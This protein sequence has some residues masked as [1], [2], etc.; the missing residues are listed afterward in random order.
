MIN[1]QKTTM[2]Y[3]LNVSTWIS[4][5]SHTLNT[6]LS[7]DHVS[8]EDLLLV[9]YVLLA[10]VVIIFVNNSWM[11]KDQDENTP[12][13]YSFSQLCADLKLIRLL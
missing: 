10:L 9:S 12:I 8:F 3:V 4:T 5:H 7:E 1:L 6:P 2:I 13:S 11:P